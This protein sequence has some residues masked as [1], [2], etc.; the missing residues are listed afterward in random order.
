MLSHVLQRIESGDV[1]LSRANGDEKLSN[2]A[3]SWKVGRG[4]KK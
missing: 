3:Q 4:I 1:I 2:A